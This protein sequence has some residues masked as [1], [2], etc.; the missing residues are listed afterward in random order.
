VVDVGDDG[1]VADVLVHT[2]LGVCGGCGLRA[3]CLGVC[4]SSAQERNQQ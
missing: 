4:A 1:D 3:L 2:V